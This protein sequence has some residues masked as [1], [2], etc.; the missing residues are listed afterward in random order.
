MPRVPIDEQHRTGEGGAKFPRLKMEKGEYAR[1]ALLE[2]PWMEWVHALRAPII[3]N[4][5]AKK[6]KTTRN[7]EVSETWDTEWLGNPICLGNPDVLEDKGSDP[8]SCPAC[9]AAQDDP[10]F[11]P[12]RRYAAN[13]VRYT[14]RGGTWTPRTPLSLEIVIW[15]FTARMYDDLLTLQGKI[16]PLQ[17]HDITLEC[18][19]ANYQR[20][21]MSFELEPAWSLEDGG[22]QLVQSTWKGEGNRATDEQLKKA[23]GSERSRAQIQEDVDKAVRNWAR[24]QA[25]AAGAGSPLDA[26]SGQL[27]GGKDLA[28]AADALLGGNGTPGPNPGTG[29]LTEFAGQAQ[30]AE[31]NG[32]GPLAGI[33]GGPLGAAGAAGG[34]PEPAPAPTATEPAGTPSAPPSDDPLAGVT[35]GS[36]T[37]AAPA[38]GKKA[39]FD[40]LMEG[41]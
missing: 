34:T 19:D 41:L 9:E 33:G 6:K 4:G 5:V 28:A 14:L 29:G 17:Q 3:E 37:A 36:A 27:G 31:A 38:A 26:G 8:A 25:T 20:M 18:E 24:A 11:K 7:G 12:Q 1:F 2:Q 13:I 32:G 39:S 22:V 21:K 30:P 23:C 40:Q 10:N 16:G 35:P 15:G